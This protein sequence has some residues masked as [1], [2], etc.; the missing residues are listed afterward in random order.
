MLPAGA[1]R[2]PTVVTVPEAEATA[3]LLSEPYAWVA[4]AVAYLIGS[5]PFGLIL[6]RFVRG[7]DLRTIGSGNIGAT[8]AIRA[9][10][11]PWGFAVFALDLLKGYLPVLLVAPVF[12][13]FGASR[14]SIDL[15]QVLVGAAAVVGHCYPIYL[16][17]RGG[18]GVATGCGAIVAIEPYVFLW[19]G[20]AWLATRLLSGYAG[21]SSILMGLTF[22]IAIYVMHGVE[23]R[24]LLVGATGLALLILLRHRSNIQR[25]IQGTEPNARDKNKTSGDRTHATR[26]HG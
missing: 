10:G 21:L 13:V 9:M 8:N 16:R 20:S 26:T 23:R 14:E 6:S 24:A 2:P 19:G 22:P 15:L 3:P 1:R 4:V 18:K 11:R 5:I 12:E 25:M 17:F 7:V